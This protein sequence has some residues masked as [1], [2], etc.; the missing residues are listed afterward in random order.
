MFVVL[1]SGVDGKI[2]LLS[3]NEMTP[4]QFNNLARKT[5]LREIPKF[6]KRGLDM[7][8]LI[9]EMSSRRFYIGKLKGNIKLSYNSSYRTFFTNKLGN[10][11]LVDYK[12]DDDIRKLIRG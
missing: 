4:T 12:F 9:M 8:K 7:E 11:Q 2:H 1:N 5:G 3:L 6:N 10:I